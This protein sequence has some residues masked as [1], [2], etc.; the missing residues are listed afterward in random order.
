[1][2][3]L[4]VMLGSSLG[5]DTTHY[6]IADLMLDRTRDFVGREHVFKRIDEF[7]ARNPSGYLTIEGYWG[8]GKSA[9]LAEYIRRNGC[10]YFNMRA[11]G[12]VSAAQ[13]LQN[14]CAQ[15]IAEANFP[16]ASLPADATENGAF[17]LKLLREAAGKQV[18]GDKLIIAVDVWMKLI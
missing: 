2:I 17:M 11:L 1:M 14:I 8:L 4:R 9:I 7:I 16:Y 13:F 15:L 18:V 5:L 10:L 12:I 3:D 6:Q